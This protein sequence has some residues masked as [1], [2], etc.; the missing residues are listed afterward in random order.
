MSFIPISALHGDNV[1]EK[2][3]NMD[4]YHGPLCFT[5]WNCLP[6]ADADHVHARSPSSGSSVR[7][8]T[9]GTTSG[10]RRRAAGGFSNRV[11]KS[12][13]N[14]PLSELIKEIYGSNLEP[15]QEAFA[16]LSC[17]I[18]LRTTSTSA[19]AT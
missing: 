12:W 3:K 8:Q 2:S 19:G 10:I 14:P 4:W 11:T 7:T 1:V 16:P 6:K 15:I 13:C 9:N 5:T 17:T 18:T